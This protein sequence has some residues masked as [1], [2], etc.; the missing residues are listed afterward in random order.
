MAS[1]K[2]LEQTHRSKIIWI[3]RFT[4]SALFVLSAFAKMFPIESFEKQLVSIAY[5]PGLLHDFTNWC[6]KAV[7]ARIIVIFELFIG[8]ALLIPFLQKRFTLPLAITMLFVFILHLSYQI[9]LFGNTGNCGCMGELLPMSP[10]NAIIKNVISIALL[11]YLFKFSPSLSDENPVFHVLLLPGVFFFVFVF[12]PIKKTCCCDEEINTRVN[13]EVQILN[14]RID[15]LEYFIQSAS[16][17]GKVVSDSVP[18]KPPRKEPSFVSE[19]HN[20]T[21]YEINGKSV[22]SN[23]D[24][25]KSIVCVFNPDCDHCLEMAKKLK[26]IKNKKLAKI[27]FLF[28]NPDASDDNEMRAQ[29]KAF[30]SNAGLAVPFKIIERNSFDRLLINSISGPPR[31]TILENGKIIY[32]CHAENTLDVN[33]V[34]SLGKIN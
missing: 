25:G 8:F 21:E 31:L 23:P 3:I 7:W 11:V 2:S 32:D 19:F 14:D 26:S 17:T 16:S 33:K 29:I 9:A 12:W 22:R 4:I 30:L 34:R 27:Q 20:Y 18:K 28:F 6:T 10:L 24:E 13:Q 5:K 15:S 1:F